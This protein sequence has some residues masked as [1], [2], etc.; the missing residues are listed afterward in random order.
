LTVLDFYEEPPF[1]A[2][3]INGI[4]NLLL[5]GSSSSKHQNSDLA[6]GCGFEN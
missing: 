2:L 5:G 3:H 6:S 4:E 1:P